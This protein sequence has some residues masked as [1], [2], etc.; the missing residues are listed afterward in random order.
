MNMLAVAF[1]GL[2]MFVTSRSLPAST[3]KDSDGL[4]YAAGVLLGPVPS[5]ASR[6]VRP[7]RQRLT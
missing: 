7:R 4:T 3:L 6:R 1:C 2:L 5:A